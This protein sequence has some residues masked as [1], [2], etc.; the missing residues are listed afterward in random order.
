MVGVTSFGKND[1]DE[2]KRMIGFMKQNP[3]KRYLVFMPENMWEKFGKP[4][5]IEGYEVRINND[6]TDEWMVLV[7]DASPRV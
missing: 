1:S 4:D 2:I 5:Y 6:L 3:V 7:E